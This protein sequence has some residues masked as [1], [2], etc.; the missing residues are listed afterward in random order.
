MKGQGLRPLG[1][2]RGSLFLQ[3]Q[4]LAALGAFL[5][6]REGMLSSARFS[7]GTCMLVWKV[8]A[9]VLVRDLERTGCT[10]SKLAEYSKWGGMWMCCRAGR[11]CRGLGTLWIDVLRAAA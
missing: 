5:L 2:Q 9:H 10:F 3:L 7:Y 4:N 6:S 11:L 8:S 1:L